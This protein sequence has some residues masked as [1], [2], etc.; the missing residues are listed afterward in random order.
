MPT[1]LILRFNKEK[2]RCSVP[3]G[4]H[5]CRDRGLSPG[6]KFMRAGVP[7]L[8]WNCMADC[9][10]GSEE[11]SKGGFQRH[12]NVLCEELTVEGGSVRLCL[13]CGGEYRK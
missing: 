4:V 3:V 11:N 6:C 9:G 12:F 5:I 7:F 13:T 2:L 10:T 1:A 8:E